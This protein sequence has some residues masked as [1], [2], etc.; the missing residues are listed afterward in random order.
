MSL[1]VG[2]KEVCDIELGGLE[3]TAQSKQH[4]KESIR[5]MFCLLLTLVIRSIQ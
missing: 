2:F 5:R 3:L 4:I 1:E